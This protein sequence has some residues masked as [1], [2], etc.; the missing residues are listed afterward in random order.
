MLPQD[1]EEDD[2][3][4]QEDDGMFDEIRRMFGPSPTPPMESSDRN[5]EETADREKTPSPADDNILE[6]NRPENDQTGDSD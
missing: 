6:R 5:F 3:G 1:T 2:A 4:F